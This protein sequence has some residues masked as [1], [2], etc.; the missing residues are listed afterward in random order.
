MLYL[1]N[2]KVHVVLSILYVTVMITGC[3][4][5]AAEKGRRVSLQPIIWGRKQPDTDCGS[6]IAQ[7]SKNWKNISWRF[8]AKKKKVKRYVAVALLYI[9]RA[10]LSENFQVASRLLFRVQRKKTLT[11]VWQHTPVCVWSA[12][13]YRTVTESASVCLSARMRNTAED[14]VAE[15]RSEDKRLSENVD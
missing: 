7:A 8:S 4:L 14:D 11:Q 15:S 12:Q 5:Q 3:W 9:H 6:L 13:L 1:H 10:A 2:Q